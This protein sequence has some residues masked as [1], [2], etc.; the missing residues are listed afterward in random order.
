MASTT[1]QRGLSTP[2]KTAPAEP[3]QDSPGNWRHPR[4]AEITRR[5]Q[6]TT[7][8]ERNINKIA[9]NVVALIALFFVYRFTARYV[10]A[11]WPQ[12]RMA[13]TYGFTGICFIPIFNIITAAYPAV[14]PQD[15][16][17]DIPLTPGQRKLLGLP[18]SSR[19]ATPGSV[20]S[21]PPRYA[22]TPSL[23]GS[24]SAKR[25]YS[26]PPAEVQSSHAFYRSPVDLGD[27]VSSSGFNGMGSTMSSNFSMTPS[28]SPLLQ[29]A[30]LGARRSSIGSL[31]S[32]A[33]ASSIFGGF[34]G[35]GPDSPTPN[36][37]AKR[38][39]VGLNN[40]WLYE[41]GRGGAGQSFLQ[42]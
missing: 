31:G 19:P 29:R 41:R 6:K 9:Y 25:N 24:A 2:T 4:L 15:D 37:A 10:P 21:T 40:K 39:S 18:P 11:T 13:A 38:S 14:V 5:Q 16:L 27:S 12:L 35:L 23:S 17:S 1:L 34:G 33:P 28:G 7:F 30:M 36:P 26:D 8:G 20:Y 42:A 32:P 3:L 22:R